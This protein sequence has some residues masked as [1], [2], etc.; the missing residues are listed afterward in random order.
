M[1]YSQ[2]L[3]QGNKPN[4]NFKCGVLEQ[5][6]IQKLLSQQ[7]VIDSIYVTET[8]VDDNL[9]SRLRHMSQQAGGQERLEKFLNR[10]L[11]Q[12]K[13]EMRSSVFEQLK[14]NKMQQSI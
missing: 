10:S 8:E 13:E 7:A 3:A 1:Q 4:E 2:W 6:I 12:Y 9:N 11:L 5:L 14:A